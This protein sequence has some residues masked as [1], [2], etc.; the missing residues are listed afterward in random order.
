M[1]GCFSCPKAFGQESQDRSQQMQ[2]FWDLAERQYVNKE[3][4]EAIKNYKI[5]VLI[6]QDLSALNREREGF[7]LQRLGLM[8]YQSNQNQEAVKYF[9]QSLTIFR[10]L[11][12]RDQEAESLYEMGWAYEKISFQDALRCYTES[13]KIFNERGNT[14]REIQA[15]NNQGNAI[16]VTGDLEKG[17]LTIQKSLTLNRNSLKKDA[18]EQIKSLRMIG[19]I[20][21]ARGESENALSVFKEALIDKQINDLNP[22]ETSNTLNGIASVLS[23]QGKYIEATTY[24]KKSLEISKKNNYVQSQAGS[25]YLLSLLSL[26]S[27]ALQEA[28]NTL[29]KCLEISVAINDVDSQGITHNLLAMTNL[30]LGKK[31]DAYSH[32][33]KALN[34]SKKVTSNLIKAKIFN[35]S[36]AIVSTKNHSRG[37][38]YLIQAAKIFKDSNIAVGEY[39]SLYMLSLLS[40]S[41][42]PSM[43]LTYAKQSLNVIRSKNLPPLE[44]EALLSVGISYYG[45]KDF[46]NALINLKESYFI[47]Q[48]FGSGTSQ[49][50]SL[51]GIGIIYEKQNNLNEAVLHLEKSLN[52]LLSIRS[53]LFG[54]QEGNT[55]KAF[56][57]SFQGFAGTLISILIKQNKFEKAYEYLNLST[58][59]ELADYSR[60]INAKT[61]DKNLQKEIG[62]W[63]QENNRLVGMRLRAR[64]EISELVIK[65]IRNLEIALIRQTENLVAKYP[66]AAELFESKPTDIKVLQASIPDGMAIIHPV[67]TVRSGNDP[68]LIT[69]FVLSKNR[70]VF[71]KQ[72]EFSKSEIETLLTK[73]SNDLSNASDPDYIPSLKKLY[74]L[75]IL[76]VEKE[77]Q[78]IN[79][80]QLSFIASGQLRYIPFE[81]L[82]QCNDSKCSSGQHLIQ[83]YPISYLTRISTN[84]LGS[85]SNKLSESKILAVGNPVPKK[86]QLLNGAESEAQSITNL[87]PGSQTLLRDKATFDAFQTKAPRFNI[88]HL[89]THGCFQKGGC[90]DIG[91]DENTI[92]F[93]DKQ[94]KIADAALLGLKDVDLIT[95]SACQTAKETDRDGQQL[96]GLAYIFERAGAKS[97]IATLWSVDDKVTSEIMLKFY[98]NLKLGMT[99][100]EALQK[101]KLPYINEHPSLWAPFVLIG[102]PR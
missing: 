26:N 46:P 39:E 5:V 93:A 73:T 77:I 87:F 28:I 50:L 75:L 63:N 37:E 47:Q 11:N 12:N 17:L 23:I 8:Y 32:A 74:D 59:T 9:Q 82:Y 41:K 43:S 57:N 24:I 44:A 89:A 78:E 30:S 22:R 92:L 20:Y 53:G 97:V 55:R 69:I 6:A 21:V 42:N 98:Q 99:K 79:P 100:A 102:D 58:T 33:E 4:I 68:D 67:L 52:I 101:A 91:L 65:Q 76:P 3:Y 51:G 66:E 13:V 2:S 96:S 49:A 88:L 54:E 1:V 90:K 60:L 36:G 48:K 29:D 19:S 86:P 72:F 56:T 83:K 15:L 18:N 34:A 27:G 38:E 40:A 25:Y 95:L 70:K 7:A 31:E 84:S 45:I 94:L 61:I 14:L 10:Q 16:A 35:Y 62:Q 71:A 85:Q 81:A 64:V 80:K